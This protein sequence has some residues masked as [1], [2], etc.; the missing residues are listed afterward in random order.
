[1]PLLRWDI[2][3]L[4]TS[5]DFKEDHRGTISRG[6]NA[7]P[8][9]HMCNKMQTTHLQLDTYEGQE[10]QRD[11]TEGTQCLCDPK[12][13]RVQRLT[14][15]LCVAHLEDSLLSTEDGASKL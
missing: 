12:L 8:G 2:R 14:Q 11:F 10:F 1:M 15:S 7:T 5:A 6:R 3:V 4:R 9:Y 13:D